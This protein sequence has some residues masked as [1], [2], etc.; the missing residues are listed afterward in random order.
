MDKLKEYMEE[1][2]YRTEF[3]EELVIIGK[4]MVEELRDEE[5]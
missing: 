1:K 4:E 3:I 5:V 2:G